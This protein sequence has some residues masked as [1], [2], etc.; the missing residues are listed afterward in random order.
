[1]SRSVAVTASAV[2]ADE[3]RPLVAAAVPRSA[4]D[5]PEPEFVSTL[6]VSSAWWLL[7]AIAV[8]QSLQG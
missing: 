2:I 8:I 4:P 1:M 3:P 7:V 6:V 5:R